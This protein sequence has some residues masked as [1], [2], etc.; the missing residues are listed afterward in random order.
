[1]NI[2][3]RNKKVALARWNR[4]HTK[5]KEKIPN[6]TQSLLI[7]AAICGFLAGDGSVQKRKEKKFY[8][9]QIDFFPD[10]KV[11]METYMKQI[12]TIYNK[13]TKIKN[14]NK[15]YSV[16]FTSKII[17]E[18]ICNLANFG[19]KSWTLPKSLFKIKG[20]KENWLK[21]FFSAE[22]YVNNKCIKIQ[23]INKKGMK[24]I[25]QILKDKGID[26]N[27]YEYDSKK[28]PESPVSIIFISKKESRLKFHNQI[29]FWHS[30]K[31]KT[32]KES[33]GL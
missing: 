9:Y 3:R 20:A 31:T 15:F 1:M 8:H 14:N 12:K 28:K 23:T 10:D 30:K 29:G 4:I 18:D 6:D 24:E 25:S 5:Q 7:K 2:S 11:M 17:H 27:Y 21:A 13:N 16:R 22:A 32:L 26:N 19:L 33:L